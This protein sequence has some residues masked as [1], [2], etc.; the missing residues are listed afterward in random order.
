MRNEYDLN[1]AITFFLAGLGIGSFLAIVLSPKERLRLEES[2]SWPSGGWKG[3][4]RAGQ[5]IA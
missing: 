4:E 2:R 5:R 1:S 3:G